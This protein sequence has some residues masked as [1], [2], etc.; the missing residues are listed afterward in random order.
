MI[1]KFA[2]DAVLEVQNFQSAL[3]IR[4]F[5]ETNRIKVE[6]LLSAINRL[7]LAL[8]RYDVEDCFIQASPQPLIL[9]AHKSRMND[10]SRISADVLI[11][12]GQVQAVLEEIDETKKSVLSDEE[13]QEYRD[14]YNSDEIDFRTASELLEMTIEEFSQFWND[15]KRMKLLDLTANL[16][17]KSLDKHKELRFNLDKLTLAVAK[18][19][20]PLKPAPPGDLSL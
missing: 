1:E 11:S 10:L 18:H 20:E 17:K 16:I 9:Q 7:R 12:V 19:K 2:N 14:F 8:N 4:A 15:P 5:S 13:K 6:F 3:S